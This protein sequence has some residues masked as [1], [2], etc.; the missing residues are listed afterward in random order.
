MDCVN[1]FSS[2]DIRENKTIA[3]LSYLLFFLPFITAKNSAFAR[4]HANQS[5]LLLLLSIGGKVILSFLPFSGFLKGIFSMVLF[6]V[7]VVMI[8]T[9][10][11]GQA[12]KLPFIGD[13]T[14]IHY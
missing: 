1:H 11:T 10:I 3:A 5:L 6:L 13:I 7:Y 2:T 8:A 4:F 14:L 12:R 9:T